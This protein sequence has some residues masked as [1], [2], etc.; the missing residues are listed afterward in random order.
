MS[1]KQKKLL[2]M[3]MMIT[4]SV[5]FAQQ[6]VSGTVS[7][8]N[9]PLPGAN[10]IV[11]GTTNGE[12]T[13][14]DG[15]FTL[16]D[17]P[18]DGTLVITFLGFASQEISVNG[19]ST[20]NV[21]MVE[22]ANALDEVIVVGYGSQSRA[23]VTGAITTIGTKE[24][25]EL[26]ITRADQALQGRAAGVTVTNNGSP[27]SNATI[28]IRGLGTVNNNSP[29]VVIDG[30]IGGRLSDLNPNDIET[31]T[32]LK[33]ASTAAIY[34]AL[35]SNGVILVVT[36][37]GQSGVMKLNFDSWV[38]AQVQ[39]NRFDLLN[40][41]QYIQYATEI[42]QLQNP[43]AIPLR[44]TDPQY[45]SYLDTDTDW[46]DALVQVGLGQNYN[47]SA[48]GGGENSNYMMS[49]GYLD[50]EGTITSTGYSR[51]NLRANSDFTLGKFKIGQRFSASFSNTNPF[52]S[53]PFVN[54]I[55]MT[56]YF[57]VY[58]P[59]NLG[60]FQGPTSSLDNSDPR[61]PVRGVELPT[62]D[63]TSN[64]FLGNAYVSYEIIEGL[65]LKTDF[66][67]ST[68][69]WWNET[70]DPSYNDNE[71]DGGGQHT[72]LWAIITKDTGR[73]TSFNWTNSLDYSKTFNDV[74]NF[75][76]LLIAEM[77]QVDGVT[78]NTTSTNPVTDELENISNNES[79][80]RS[81]SREYFRQGFL[82]RVNYDYDGKYIVAASIRA[83]ASS[84]FGSENRWGTFPSLAVGWNI[85]KEDFLSE[86]DLLSNLKVRSSWGVTGS[87]RIG[88]YQY[89][90]GLTTNYNYNFGLNEVLGVGTTAIGP[91]DPTLKWEET[92]MFNVGVD[93][94]FFNNALSLTL[95]Y[96]NNRSDDLLMR[97]PLAP[98][99]I[100][101]NNSI[102]RNVGS[103][104]TTGFEMTIDYNHSKGGDFTWG[105]NFNLGTSQNEVLS[106]GATSQLTGGVFRN[107]AISRT[108]VGE[109]MFQFFGLQTDGIFQT[110]AEVDA[111]PSQSS[112][113][114]GDIRFKDNNGDGVI[115][116][117]DRVFI[118]NPFPDLTFGLSA[119]ASYKNLDFAMFWSGVSGNSIYNALL[120]DL[121]GMTR[122]F[123]GSTA[124]LD[125]WTGPGTSNTIP[126]ALG[127]P[128]NV[129]VSDRFVED[130]SFVRLRN[131][132]VGYTI[133][134]KN[135]LI[136]K[137]RV[138]FSAQNLITFTEY[139]G[140]D[141][142]VGFANPGNQRNDL[143]GIDTGNYPTPVSYTFGLQI[144]F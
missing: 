58:N 45:A 137:F 47:I 46:Q 102:A 129:S 35:G 110:Q 13:D 131:L 24:I 76:G 91:A 38:G 101:H 22:D 98:S 5:I 139:S 103:V 10:I 1:S 81:S 94:G 71:N 84:R 88:D 138:Y 69:N 18:S 8:A 100:V 61:N 133:P 140:L 132:A 28:R 29:L 128:R 11:K 80:V 17:V 120:Y 32:V 135:E 142:E 112:A 77:Q 60:G 55:R 75:N 122:L 87:D 74:H 54:A 26:P 99:L 42:G 52:R 85:I 143:L 78:L 23:V 59:D 89:S 40:T 107:Q 4:S 66:A 43:V 144:S 36:K 119:N 113:E 82:A 68:V 105:V 49:V 125:R 39:K 130:G 51:L 25:T 114:P 73:S 72:R 53:N 31:I 86:S 34:G 90:S 134:L 126:R 127:A 62:R 108:V 37:K 16:N 50:Q 104:E 97:E 124:M 41:E 109:P 136:S 3:V 118:G 95:E 19:Q 67:I 2:F 83:D 79:N 33:D 56:P 106:L 48:S 92:T 70:F 93:V 14:F 96:Y 20:I 111:A 6:T 117:G 63:N 65:T 121:D 15:N 141:P 27:G 44:I 115:N 9:G 64:N 21:T 123:N 7:D 30:V 12:T 116:D 57:K